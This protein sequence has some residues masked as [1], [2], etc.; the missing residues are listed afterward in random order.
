MKVT[1]LDQKFTPV[2]L[3]ITIETKE[4]LDAIK[5]VGHI[6]TSN[7]CINNMTTSPSVD[8]IALN[9]IKKIS[10]VI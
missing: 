5:K 6:I 4:E 3:A 2:N 1:L 9:V 7:S 8:L 10:E